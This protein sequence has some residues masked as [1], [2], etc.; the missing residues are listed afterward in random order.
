MRTEFEYIQIPIAAI[1]RSVCVC[2]GGGGISYFTCVKNQ[3]FN[4]TLDMEVD[5]W[6]YMLKVFIKK[7]AGHFIL[8]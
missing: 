1:L 8:T 6:I 3:G 4:I 2:K 5:Q 7:R